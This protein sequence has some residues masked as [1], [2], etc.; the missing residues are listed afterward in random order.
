MRQPERPDLVP[1]RGVADHTAGWFGR[2]LGA[3]LLAAERQA[4]SAALG[5]LFGT[6]SALFAVGRHEVDL[7]EGLDFAARHRFAVGEGNGLFEA[8]I[9]ARPS[10][11]PLASESLRLVVLQHV[12][13]TM[14][15]PADFLSECERVLVPGGT[16]AVLCLNPNGRS[17]RWRQDPP[18]WVRR[19]WRAGEIRQAVQQ[20]AL[21]LRHTQPVL[22]S[23]FWWERL[24]QGRE[25]LRSGR[26]V[27]LLGSAYLIVFNKPRNGARIIPL[28]QAAHRRRMSGVTTTVGL[29]VRRSRSDQQANVA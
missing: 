17:L 13:E 16:L 5:D 1:E 15:D 4:C 7:L 29:P 25:Q 10:E 24:G 26:T 11:L 8:P 28:G 19:W 22:A 6:F 20:R 3:D 9:Q 21:D 12:L 14:R 23:R 2:P 18:P 27:G